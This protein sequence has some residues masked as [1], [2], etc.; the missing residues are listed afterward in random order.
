MT[1]SSS[2]GAFGQQG[3]FPR[4]ELQ[5]GETVIFEGRPSMVA[6]CLLGIIW[7]VLCLGGGLLVAIFTIPVPVCAVSALVVGVLVGAV[8]FLYFYVQWSGTS[9]A[10]TDKRVLVHK[11]DASMHKMTQSLPLSHITHTVRTQSFADGLVGA[12]NIG[13]SAVPGMSGFMWPS[14]PGHDTVRPFI[15]EQLNRY[16]GPLPQPQAY[17]PQPLQYPGYA[18]APPMQAPPAAPP[19]GMA[20]AQPMMPSRQCSGCGMNVT[21][22]VPVCPYCGAR[23]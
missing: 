4:N 20:P 22:G 3:A 18:M 7:L 13:F 19:A 8:P 23:M 6:M 14:V 16:R 9:F 10:M 5:A 17:A 2:A 11:T 12:G 1:Q 15:D 21:G